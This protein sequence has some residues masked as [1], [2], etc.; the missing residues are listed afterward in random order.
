MP[1]LGTAVDEVKIVKWRF[2]EGASVKRGDVLADIETDKAEMEL[3]SIATGIL[4]RK[5]VSEGTTVSSGTIVAYVG[6]PGEEVTEPKLETGAPVAA[7]PASGAQSPRA[8][9]RVSRVVLNLA[10]KLNV[11]LSKMK[12]TGAGGMIT[13]EDVLAAAKSGAE[14]RPAP[15]ATLPAGVPI[16]PAVI[17][18]GGV[19]GAVEGLTRRQAAV[20]RVVLKSIQEVPHLRIVASIDMMAVQNLRSQA[21]ARGS[22]LGYDAIFLKAMASAMKVMPL[23]AARLVGERL[24]YPQRISI[25]MA[26]GFENELFLPVVHGADHKNLLEIQAEIDDLLS[27]AKAGSFKADAMTDASMSLSNLGM[28]PIESFEA[29]IFPGQSAILAVG[30]V[31]EKAVIVE[32][33]V[34]VKPLVTVNLSAD[35][36]YINGR[37]AAQFVAKVKEIIEMGEFN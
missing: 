10:E 34:A 6:K 18:A 7:A 30:A 28:Y 15:T 21:E 19:A 4:L 16:E 3:E 37:T 17:P 36:R 9:Q 27:Q 31:R 26:I 29:I 11:D 5:L 2:P 12:G 20:A 24:V 33:R 8:T 1:D 32:G 14:A 22:R 25:A 23:M 35:H 13:R